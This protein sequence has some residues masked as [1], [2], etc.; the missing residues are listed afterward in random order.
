MMSP[1]DF[2]TKPTLWLWAIDRFRATTIATTTFGLDH[3]GR[4][5]ADERIAGLDLSA[6]SSRRWGGTHPSQRRRRVLP[7]F[8]P[9]GFHSERLRA[10]LRTCG[11]VRCGDDRARCGASRGWIMS[12]PICWRRRVEPFPYAPDRGAHSGVRWHPIND[13]RSGSST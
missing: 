9:Y 10:G 7:R 1:V 8:E 6:S 5:V 13:N 11:I 3:V 4:R 2:L 12:T